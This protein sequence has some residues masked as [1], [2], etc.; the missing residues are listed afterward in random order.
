MTTKKKTQQVPYTERSQPVHHPFT[1]AELGHIVSRQYTDENVQRHTFITGE[2]EYSL[3]P[4]TEAFQFFD[5]PTLVQPLLDQGFVPQKTTSSRGGLRMHIVFSNPNG[6]VYDDPCNWD[7]ESWGASTGLKDSI[8]LHGGLRP[9]SGFHYT[10]GFFR[11]ICTNGLTVETL[12]L[13]KADF[14]HV[15]FD[16]ST[17]A[18]QLFTG[19]RVSLGTEVL[20][21]EPVGTKAGL[22]KTQSVLQRAMDAESTADLPH[23]VREL[24]TPVTELPQKYLTET[25]KQFEQ[26][27]QNASRNKVYEM[28]LANILTSAQNKL[29]KTPSRLAF[30]LLPAQRSLAKLTGIFSL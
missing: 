4:T 29:E 27:V 22:K 28:D 25:F 7:E 11:M 12:G 1:Q 18:A 30:K 10:R 26:L 24:V 8:V 19:K 16:E 13:G 20:W 14:N 15:T 21:G 2:K 9:G 5:W 3:G 23:F 6:P 17:L